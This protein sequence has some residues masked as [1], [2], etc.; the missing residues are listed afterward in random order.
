MNASEPLALQREIARELQVA[1]S[2]EAGAEIERR[3]ASSRNG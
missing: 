2:F 3:V 1:E